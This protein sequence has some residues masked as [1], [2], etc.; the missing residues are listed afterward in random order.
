M[1]L[2]LVD[3][4]RSLCFCGSKQGL[5]LEVDIL[6]GVEVLPERGG[7][8]TPTEVVEL[9]L[10]GCWDGRLADEFLVRE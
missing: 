10:L 4:N 8:S 7:F 3:S 6:R 9:G 1:R 5:P 2:T